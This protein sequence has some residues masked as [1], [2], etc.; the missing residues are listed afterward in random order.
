MP[1]AP[2]AQLMGLLQAAAARAPAPC[3]MLCVVVVVD[4]SADTGAVQDAV[5]CACAHAGAQRV[6]V[7]F[8]PGAEALRLGHVAHDV[9][10]GCG[11]DGE[12]LR[13]GP[14][15]AAADGLPALMAAVASSAAALIAS[16]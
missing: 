16:L 13:L 5:Q 3:A 15:A 14:A 6:F 7:A 8:S 9:G 12:A 4:A 1:G 11:W 2:P 10:C